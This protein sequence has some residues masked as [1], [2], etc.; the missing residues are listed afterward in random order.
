[1]S[2]CSMPMKETANPVAAP[3]VETR[4]VYAHG[5]AAIVTLLISVTFGILASLEL[6]LPDLAGNHVWLSWG[7]LRYDHT[8]GIMLGWL[9][10]AFFAF[11]Y[12]AVPLLTGRPVTSVRLGQWIFGLW[13]FA[14]V[15]PGW[16][17]VLAGFSQPL[18]WAEFPIVVDVFVVLALVLAI[19]QFLPPFFWRGLEDLYVSSWYV[20][21]ALVFTLAGLPHGQLRARVC[22]RGARRRLQRTVDS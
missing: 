9:G 3:A 6:L 17:L 4:L 21:G 2:V 11:L 19:V 10:N 8:Q 14:V 13:N 12:H 7:R 22:P 16:I 18:E 5:L 1:M 15:A 20:I